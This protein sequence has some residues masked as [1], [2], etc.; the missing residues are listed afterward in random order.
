VVLI[1]LCMLLLI[2]GASESATVNA[3]MV[4]IK[5]GVLLPFVVLAFTAFN[6]D[7][8]ANFFGQASGISGAAG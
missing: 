2:R 4:C 5:L 3:I 7:H 1:G 8:F 6:S